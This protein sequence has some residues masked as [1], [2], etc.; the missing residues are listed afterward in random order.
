MPM[1]L[2]QISSYQ[3]IL[4]A[5]NFGHSYTR[6]EW[7]IPIPQDYMTIMEHGFMLIEVLDIGDHL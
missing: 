6:Y 5:A 2:E 3:G 4:M 7:Q 1:K